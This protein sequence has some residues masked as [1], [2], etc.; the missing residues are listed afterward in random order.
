MEPLI[1]N[2]LAAKLRAAAQRVQIAFYGTAAQA[3]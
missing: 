3:S 1:A 2:D